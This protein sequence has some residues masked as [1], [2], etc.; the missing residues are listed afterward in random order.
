MLEELM[1]RI[2]QWQAETGRQT[3]RIF[4]LSV[5]CSV[6]AAGP[7]VGVALLFRHLPN[8]QLLIFPS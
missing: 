1:S 2:A 8:C 4:G 7:V 6:F 5:A 3:M